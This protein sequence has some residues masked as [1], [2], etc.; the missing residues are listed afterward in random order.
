MPV[1]LDIT[2]SITIRTEYQEQMNDLTTPFM[3]RTGG[4]N[5][6]LAEHD[7]H[8]FESFIQPGFSQDNNV[9]SM[10]IEQRNYETIIDIKTLGYVIGEGKNQEQPKVVVRENAVEIKF[11]REK[12]I[13]GEI[14]EH[15]DKTGF[16]IE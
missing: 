1:Y 15:I 8:R 7:G 12:V 2:Y 13:F 5:Y 16:Y 11:P 3:T 9:S 4:I 10:D 14:P 6:F